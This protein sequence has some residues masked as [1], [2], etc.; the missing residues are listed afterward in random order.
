MTS[1]GLGIFVLVAGLAVLLS[2]AVVR[3]E[4]TPPELALEGPLWLGKQPRDVTFGARDPGSGLRRI[5]VV[6]ES[7]GGAR[8]LLETRAEGGW[9]LGTAKDDPGSYTVTLNAQ[10]L[11]D[12]E[13]TLRVRATDWSWAHALDGNTAEVAVPVTIDTKPPPLVSVVIRHGGPTRKSVRRSASRRSPSSRR[14]ARKSE[15]MWTDSATPIAITMV[16]TIDERMS[17]CQPSS[18]MEASESTTL[19]APTES[20]PITPTVLRK[21]SSSRRPITPNAESVRRPNRPPSELA[22]QL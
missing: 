2:V 3:C 21:K 8:T 17:A 12:G 22:I 15:M 19:S 5:E 20:G 6:L 7:T 10:G 13:A 18:Q 14:L 1:S 4:G 16:G 11:R 9:L